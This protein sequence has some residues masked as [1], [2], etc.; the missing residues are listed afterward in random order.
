VSEIDTISAETAS[1]ILGVS[2]RLLYDLS[3]PRGPIPCFRVGRRIVFN[4]TD[5]RDYL[6][7]C[8]SV[9]IKRTVVSC[10]NSTVSYPRDESELEKLFRKDGIAPSKKCGES[11][12]KQV[13]PSLPRIRRLQQS[14][15]KM[16]APWSRCPRSKPRYPRS[17]LERLPPADLRAGLIV[18][19]DRLGS[20]IR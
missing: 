14:T 11:N 19:Q 20:G 6:Q 17:L 5:V 15:G 7:S 13:T 4:E 1:R 16:A 18:D 2:V 10:L 8:R 3:A 12:L 9:E